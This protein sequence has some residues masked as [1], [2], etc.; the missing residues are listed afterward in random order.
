MQKSL[1]Y[2][3]SPVWTR[4][5]SVSIDFDV[6]NFLNT[7][8]LKDL[9]LV[10]VRRCAASHQ[11]GFEDVQSVVSSLQ[12]ICRIIHNDMVSHQRGFE[13]VRPSWAFERTLSCIIHNG[14]VCYLYGFEDV[15]LIGIFF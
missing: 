8:H 4:R 3:F 9:S 13:D 12:M 2:G 7:P 6:N 14:M 15:Q 11:C 1:W 5:C 10:S